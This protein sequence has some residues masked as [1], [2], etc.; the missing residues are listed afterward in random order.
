MSPVGLG[1][2]GVGERGRESRE[3]V[4]F[5][6]MRVDKLEQ[7]SSAGAPAREKEGSPYVGSDVFRER[8]NIW[9]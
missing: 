3:D 8:V 2:L 6:G 1:L 4:G 5:E 7:A 9:R